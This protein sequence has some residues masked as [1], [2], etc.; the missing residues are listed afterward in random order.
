MPATASIALAIRTIAD[1]RAEVGLD[2]DQAAGGE[3]DEADRPGE[4]AERLRRRA[5]RE[6]SGKPEAERE[7]RE[8]GRLEVDDPTGS[9]RRA[10]FTLVPTT[11]TATSRT[12]LVS[13]SGPASG[14]SRRNDARER[15]RDQAD[16]GVERLA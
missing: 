10:P 14:F 13:R 7:L 4:L 9:Q 5:A 6:Q 16:D 12:K 8:L 2:D 15:H 3:D 11:S 1:R